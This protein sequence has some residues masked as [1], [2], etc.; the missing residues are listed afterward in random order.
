[1]N[2]KQL[3]EQPWMHHGDPVAEFDCAVLNL[4]RRG[5]N[6]HHTIRY[7]LGLSNVG[8]VKYWNN[9]NVKNALQRLRRAGKIKYD[10]AWAI[11]NK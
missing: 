1:M 2:V 11:V 9:H 3:Y 4:I 7:A 8:Y 6:K 10:R 5:T